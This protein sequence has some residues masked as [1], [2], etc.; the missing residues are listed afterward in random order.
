MRNKSNEDKIIWKKMLQIGIGL[1]AL[2]WIIQSAVNVYIFG[3][4]SL[5]EEIFTLNRHE[6]WMRSLALSILIMFS[7]YAQG[8]VSRRKKAEKALRESEEKFRNL[9][10]QSP[11]MI[12]LNRKGRV[13]YANRQSEQ[14]MGYQREEYYAPDF[15][16]LRL[17]S[18]QYVDLLKTNFTRHMSGEEVAPIEYELITKDGE[19]IDAIL[20][21][22][23]IDYEGEP[24][25]LGIVTDITERKRVEK[26][27][28]EAKKQAEEA[29]R[30]KSEFL[31]NM[32]HEIRTPMNA[33]IGMTGITLDT[34]LTNEQREYLNIVK[35]SAYTL[36]GLLD[37]ILDFSKIEAGK[38]ELE[39]IDFDL[40]TVVEGITDTLSHRASTKGLELA[41]LIHPEVPVF[42]RGDPVRLRQI[43]MNLGGNA[44]KYTEKGEVVIQVELQEETSDRVNV[45]FSVTDT[46][47]GIPDDNQTKIF[48]SFTQVDGSTTRKYGGTGLGLSIS[49]RLVELLNGQIGV[50]S[51]LTQGSR[52]W[53]TVT[54]EKQKEVRTIPPSIPIDLHEKRMLVVDDNRTN[55]TI[56]I[57]MLESFGCSPQAVESGAE[58]LGI[59]DNAAGQ[60]KPFDLV[61]LDMRMPE[62]DGEQTLRA[63][64]KDPRIKDVT[65]IVL[66]SVGVRGEVARL[67]ALGCEGYL[68]KPAKQSQLFDTIITVLGQK[69]ETVKPE[70][71][72]IVT[73]HFVAE[74]K[75]RQVRILVAEDNPMNQKLALALL[76]RAGYPA[77]AMDNGRMVIEALKK[78]P[79]DLIFMDVQMPEMDGFE[80]TRIIREMEGEGKH[81]PI[82]A[83][84]AHA[85]KGDRERC[86]KAGMDDYISK[87]I[88]PKE[89]FSAIEKWIKPTEKKEGTLPVN[90]SKKGDPTN[91]IPLEMEN[92][93]K[94]FDGDKE[95]FNELMLEFLD[96]VPNQLQI[97]NEAVKQGDA[98]LIERVAHGIKGA[99]GNLGAKNLA[100]SALKLE[101]LGRTGNLEN[102]EK[103]IVELMDE[104]KCVKDYVHQSLGMETAE[105]F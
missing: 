76:T 98:K 37:D 9:A 28:L 84:T 61:L 23:L 64:K 12:F 91:D 72:P 3:R 79:C 54:L 78:N 22:K 96:T 58:A 75:L 65:V 73:R 19:K 14:I 41:Y 48:E 32:S 39:T 20:T 89:M 45:L 56:L 8:V 103:L 67:E 27:L 60:N 40:R 7:I 4:G 53:F 86:L 43:L 18:P 102:A 44:V 36:L 35:E 46:G 17:T 50:E 90:K 77:E 25:I 5:L 82:V 16:Y 29:N 1:G 74:Q 13:I 97:L 62:M 47:I 63:I 83:M 92:T 52:F 38:I 51:R 59:L 34:N 94:R 105:K 31:A 6:V 26:A 87:P 15:D 80:A 93:L 85:M 57:K 11:N 100:D 104:M 95:F 21:S 2:L 42:L 33:V 49:K 10:E 66:T 88:E 70:P 68:L 30:L 69:K 55:R 81:T 99:A 101:L 24:A 71:V